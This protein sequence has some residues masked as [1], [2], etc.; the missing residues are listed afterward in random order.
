MDHSWDTQKHLFETPGNLSQALNVAL[1]DGQQQRPLDKS[2]G[3]VKETIEALLSYY[4][5]N[6]KRTCGLK[7]GSD[8]LHNQP[9][10]RAVL[11]ADIRM[12][13]EV[14]T[15]LVLS[16]AHPE[17]SDDRLLWNWITIRKANDEILRDG[18]AIGSNWGQLELL[19]GLVSGTVYCYAGTVSGRRGVIKIG[20]TVDLLDRYLKSKELAHLP[21][22]LAWMPGGKDVESLRHA[23]CQDDNIIGNEWYAP[24]ER[25]YVYIRSTFSDFEV[26]FDRRWAN[27]KYEFYGV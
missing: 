8:K 26:D 25:L 23:D 1:D 16:K 13:Y 18:F 9:R 17:L 7:Y 20:Y 15:G 19:P 22:K 10:A 24:T 4:R 11:A 27:A 2:H 3:D 6:D 14:R 12:H 21:V 5:Q